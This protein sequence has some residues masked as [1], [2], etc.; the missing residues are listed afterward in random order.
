MGFTLESEPDEDPR[1]G[2]AEHLAWF[3]GVDVSNGW[4]DE[5]PSAKGLEA[6]VTGWVENVKALRGVW[7]SQKAA[8]EALVLH[9]ATPRRA[10]EVANAVY[11]NSGR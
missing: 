11:A 6:D 8:I 4:E 10:S 3:F 9:R 1:T 2:L 5:L 7:P